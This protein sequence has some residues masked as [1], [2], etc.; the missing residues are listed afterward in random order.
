MEEEKG[1][2]Y[3]V[4]D[5]GPPELEKRAKKKAGRGYKIL[6]AISLSLVIFVVCANFA[7]PTLFYYI[8]PAVVSYI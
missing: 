4:A 6:E 3:K 2:S 5:R 7:I 1:K 8:R